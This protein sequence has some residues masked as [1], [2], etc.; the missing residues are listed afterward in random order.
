MSKWRENKMT[1]PAEVSTRSSHSDNLTSTASALESAI[2]GTVGIVLT[3]EGLD[4]ELQTLKK[5]LLD[6]AHRLRQIAIELLNV[7]RK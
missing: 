2:V 1:N 4:A 3:D 5:S 7:I 6:E